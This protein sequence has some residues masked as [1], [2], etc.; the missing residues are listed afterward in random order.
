[1]ET[2]FRGCT[3]S[4][5]INS[6]SGSNNRYVNGNQTNYNYIG[7]YESFTKYLDEVTI[8]SN[9][10][11]ER[12][13]AVKAKALYNSNKIKELKKLIIEN[14]STFTTGTFATTAGGLLLNI[15]QDM[16]K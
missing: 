10:A 15:I 6:F 4:G 9:D 12:E 11:K 16:L 13:C 1:M 3:I 2:K 8:N 14:I 7:S 5:G